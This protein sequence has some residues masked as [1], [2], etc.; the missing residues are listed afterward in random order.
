MSHLCTVHTG[1]NRGSLCEL[2][3]ARMTN[4]GKERVFLAIERD[5]EI[6]PR[7][8]VPGIT[9]KAVSGGLS[10]RYVHSGKAVC[11]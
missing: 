7:E 3:I 6:A 11:V 10:I 1:M 4:K 5:V 2:T 8:A 9:V